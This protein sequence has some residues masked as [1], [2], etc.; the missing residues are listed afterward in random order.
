[1]N[2]YKQQIKA[3]SD[4]RNA[5]TEL[6]DVLTKMI[7]ISNKY[8]TDNDDKLLN[9][10]KEEIEKDTKGYN[11]NRFLINVTP[12]FKAKHLKNETSFQGMELGHL[13]YSDN[14]YEYQITERY[15]RRQK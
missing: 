15:E 10:M 14:M 6:N 13:I 9:E 8:S 12:Q 1:M 3:I 2:L 5:V 7:A 4:L 11:K